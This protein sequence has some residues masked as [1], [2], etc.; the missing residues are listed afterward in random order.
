MKSAAALSHR[1]S[2]LFF[3]DL[4]IDL[5]RVAIDYLHFADIQNL[6]LAVSVNQQLKTYFLRTMEGMDLSVISNMSLG[7]YEITLCLSL[8]IS[9]TTINFAQYGEVGS[10]LIH[11]N[12]AR[13]KSLSFNYNEPELSKILCPNLT[14][15]SWKRCVSEN[16]FLEFVGR[17]PKLERLAIQSSF[18][19]SD[20]IIS[21]IVKHC[22]NLQHLD[23]KI[24][25]S[26][27]KILAESNLKLKKIDLIDASTISDQGL[28]DFVRSSSSLQVILFNSR[29][30]SE[31]TCRYILE[32]ATLP[33]LR[34]GERAVLPF[35]LTSLNEFIGTS[36]IV[37]DHIS[38]EIIACLIE[39]LRVPVSI[40]SPPF[41]FI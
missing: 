23:A 36:K 39:Y 2:G 31:Q 21:L 26:G 10:H 17:H 11:Q 38:P 18:N 34:S 32:K 24:G 20:P 8:K 29:F 30:F 35:C 14:S 27:L 13:I 28:V 6:H 4:P 12:A 1:R 19:L 15:F 3:V 33:T 5:Y 25:E 7:I 40:I 16:L 37:C 22:P 9:P 41:V